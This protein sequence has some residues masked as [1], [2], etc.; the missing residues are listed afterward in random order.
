MITDPVSGASYRVVDAHQHLAFG[1][2]TDPALPLGP[3]LELLDR[4]GIDRAVL[5]PP[6]GAFGGEARATAAAVNARTAR[7]VAAHPDRFL[8][9]VAHIDLNEGEAVCRRTLEEAV[10]GLGLRGAAWHHRFQGRYLDDPL[11]PGL[12]RRCGELGVPA[13]LHVISGSGLEALWRLEALLD[14]CPDTAVCALDGFSSTEQAGEITRL[15]ARHGNLFCDLGAMI[16][17]SGWTIRTFLDTVGAGRLL[18]GTDLYLTPR[19]WYAPA[20]LYEILH[21]DIDPQE[22][23]RILADNAVALFGGKRS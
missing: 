13:L 20:P 11:M 15:A 10:T 14:A 23:R 4:F 12:V 16:S 3:R 21:M 17:V 18:F 8:A 1:E 19:T 5:L 6:S 7:A 22:K 9:G 2:G